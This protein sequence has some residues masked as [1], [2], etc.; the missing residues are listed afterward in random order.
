MYSCNYL[1]FVLHLKRSDL[2]LPSTYW[3][4]TI[5]LPAQGD[6]RVTPHPY[7]NTFE[8]R[9]SGPILPQNLRWA[10]IPIDWGLQQLECSAFFW[11]SPCRSCAL[12]GTGSSIKLSWSYHFYLDRAQQTGFSARLTLWIKSSSRSLGVVTKNKISRLFRCLRVEAFFNV[13]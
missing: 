6:C 1:Y 9:K 7:L 3:W 5:F 10:P 8:L 13:K 2:C 11:C 12:W 4:K